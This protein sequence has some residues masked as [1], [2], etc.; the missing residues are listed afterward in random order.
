MALTTSDQGISLIEEFEGCALTS[1]MCP[2]GVLT[3][4]Y[5]HV[6]AGLTLG[7][8]ISPAEADALLRSDLKG[9]EQV[10]HRL[11]A[12]TLT[13]NQFDALVSFAFHLGLDNLKASTLLKKLNRGDYEGAADEFLRWNKVA[14]NALPGLTQR[15][16]AER[17]LFLGRA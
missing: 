14:G 6:A 2:A 9:L 15:R 11:V 10:I 4:G 12:V 7:H 17:D 5:S 8:T 1:Y 16:T 13:Q 3:I